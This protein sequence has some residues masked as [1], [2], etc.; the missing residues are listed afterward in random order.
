M[1]MQETSWGLVRKDKNCRVNTARA[2]TTVKFTKDDQRRLCFIFSLARNQEEKTSQKLRRKGCPMN[3]CKVCG[4][5]T[6]QLDPPSST[7]GPV[8]VPAS[9]SR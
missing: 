9:L 3:L 8:K 1:D 4:L 7:P 2:T 5:K 6:G